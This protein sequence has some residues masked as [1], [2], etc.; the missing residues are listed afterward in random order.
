MSYKAERNSLINTDLCV[1][2]VKEAI[3]S[4]GNDFWFPKHSTEKQLILFHYT[5][6]EGMKG[7][8]DNRSFHCTDVS[9][10]NDSLELKYGKKIITD[11]LDN[12]L[13]NEHNEEIKKLLSRLKEMTKIQI[14]D[15]Y[16]SCF[17]EDNNLLNQWEQYASK[18]YGYNLG[19]HFNSD[20]NSKTKISHY[21][22]KLSENKYP[23]LRKVIYEVSEQ[24]DIVN[25]YIASIIE[26]AKKALD[27]NNHI[28]KFWDAPAS[29]Y[30]A[31]IF[32]EIMLS[33]KSPSYQE[34]KEW[35]LVYM[36]DKNWKLEIRNHKVSNNIIVPFLNTYI[37]EEINGNYIF[38]LVSINSG[39]MLVRDTSKKSID[40]YVNNMRKCYQHSIKINEEII[41]N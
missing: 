20:N 28:D 1:E 10:L 2:E 13:K 4:Y 29:L 9:F 25:R 30:A 18:G 22:D 26:G 37:Y 5:Q 19:I 15:T 3:D 8:I 38:P 40:I 23:S 33:L 7:I 39:P 24:Y 12:Y 31:D 32:F 35:R 41:V 17:S 6:A 34:E 11:I 27:C 14:Y 21:L 16:V 36:I